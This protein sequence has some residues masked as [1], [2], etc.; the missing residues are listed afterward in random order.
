MLNVLLLLRTHRSKIAIFGE[1][2]RIGR[3]N[4]LCFFEVSNVYEVSVVVGHFQQIVF[5]FFQQ[6]WFTIIGSPLFFP[7]ADQP[8]DLK[9]EETNIV[10]VLEQSFEGVASKLVYFAQEM[11]PHLNTPSQ[12]LNRAFLPFQK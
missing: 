3:R 9:V 7:F 11:L 5:P 12:A 6:Y 8:D 4:K 1:K 2:K 10:N